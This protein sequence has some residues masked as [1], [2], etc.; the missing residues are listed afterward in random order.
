MIGNLDVQTLPMDVPSLCIP[1]VFKKITKEDIASVFRDLNLGRIQRIDLIARTNDKGEIVK[2]AFIH[3]TW[4]QS[5]NAT[6]ARE[7]LLC[8]NDIK[9]LYDDPWFWKVSAN[10]A[11]KYDGQR[12]DGQ[13]GEGPR[14]E[15]PRGDDRQ[16]SDDRPRG[17]ERPRR[18]YRPRGDSELLEMKARHSKTRGEQPMSINGRRPYSEV[19]KSMSKLSVEAPSFV[20]TATLV[21]PPAPMFTPS[22]P[23]YPPPDFVPSA[24]T[25]STPDYPPPGEDDEEESN[26]DYEDINSPSFDYGKIGELPVVR[27]KIKV[28]EKK[29]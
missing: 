28:P 6:R 1:R 8:G 26:S 27:R 14:V 11:Q 4:N 18:D 29:A 22:S 15:G 7:R 12:V 3:L 17:D 9:V 23:D 20:P 21:P 25:P 5:A 2:R 10:R 19:C 16:R 24:F 13:R